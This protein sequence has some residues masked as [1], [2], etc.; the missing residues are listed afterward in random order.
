[1]ARN[2]LVEVFRSPPRGGNG[3]G[4]RTVNP[5]LPVP[6]LD[7]D[8]SQLGSFT[9]GVASAKNGAVRSMSDDRNA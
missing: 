8:P 4:V 1:M 5:M 6:G 7:R 9:R 3:E 2:N